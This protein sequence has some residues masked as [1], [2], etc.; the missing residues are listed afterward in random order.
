MVGV[1]SHNYSDFALQWLL[2]E[3]AEDGDEIICV[4]VSDKDAR[5]M[6]ERQYKARADEMVENIKKKIPQHRAVSVKLE[7]AVG[8]LHSTFQKLVRFLTLGHPPN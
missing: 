4:H 7:F 8:K 1:D 5:S 6:D 2:E 3:Y